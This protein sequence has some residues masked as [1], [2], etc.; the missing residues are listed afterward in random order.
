MPLSFPSSPTVGQTSTQ[1][2]RTFTWSGYAWELSSNVA[3]HASTHGSAGSD[4]VSLDASQIATGTLADARLSGN[5]ILAANI[6]AQF[7]ASQ[8]SL[9]VFPRTFTTSATATASGS[10]FF[11][12]FTPAYALTVSQI[13]YGTSSGSTASG[14]TLCRFGLYTADSAGAVTLVARTA[15]DTSITGGPAV[16]TRTLSTT[17]GYPA[18]YAL[19]AGSRYAIAVICVATTA[20]RWE[21]I[22]HTNT[23]LSALSPR[24]SAVLTSQS[25]LP[26]SVASNGFSAQAANLVWGRVS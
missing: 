12:Y 19:T 21:N 13:A 11:T 23:V 15:S 18:T 1:N 8:S 10:V 3:G 7:H 14:V 5:V 17:G 6:S 2:G 25:D 16:F 26:T 4:A 22:N 24:I 20:P 9:D